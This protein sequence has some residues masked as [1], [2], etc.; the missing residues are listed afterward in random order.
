[1]DCPTLFLESG[2]TDNELDQALT[3]I[4]GNYQ[5]SPKIGPIF[6]LK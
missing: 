5:A 6:A 4:G 1:M 2:M 3:L